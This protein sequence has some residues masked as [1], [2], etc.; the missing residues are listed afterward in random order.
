MSFSG[1]TWEEEEQEALLTQGEPTRN[2]TTLLGVKG[3][4]ALN[5]GRKLRR[6]I[7]P[8]AE[9]LQ[10]GKSPTQPRWLP[11]GFTMEG[12]EGLAASC[13]LE[14]RIP[15]S[16]TILPERIVHAIMSTGGAKG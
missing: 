12:S 6:Q 13:A 4:A 9:M 5:L 7:G 8:S 11:C 15:G 10:R 14:A 2:N 3:Q 16:P 1:L